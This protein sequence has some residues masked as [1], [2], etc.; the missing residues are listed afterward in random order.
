MLITGF[1]GVKKYVRVL[2]AEVGQF[3]T[4]DRVSLQITQVRRVGF[5]V[6]VRY[7]MLLLLDIDNTW[8]TLHSGNTCLL[9]R[10]R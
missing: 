3:D 6:L 8:V 5:D 2:S 10:G 7:G 4:V 9:G 1:A